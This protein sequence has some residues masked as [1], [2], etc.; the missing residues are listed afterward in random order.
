M[1]RFTLGI[2]GRE[3]NP[4]AECFVDFA[5]ALRDA[6]R[7]L[8][9]EV[10]PETNPGRY[11]MFGANNLVDSENK[12]PRD[13]IIYNAEQ[14]AAISD[15]RFFLQNWV[16]YRQMIVWDYSRANVEVL[17]RLG[18]ERAVHCPVGYIS[19]M[20][21]IQSLPEEEQDIDVLFYGSVAG[22]RR[23][24]LDALDAT[25]LRVERLFGVYGA[26]RDKFIARAKVVLN[27]RFYPRGIFEIFRV[28]HL[29]ANKKCVLTEAGG[30]DTELEALADRTCA[31]V[32]RANIVEMCKKLVAA[33]NARQEI[34]ETG[35]AEFKKL[36][37]IETVRQALEESAP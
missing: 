17:R 34:A 36:N 1:S 25:G 8:G 5:K 24:I 4:H 14:L 3:R 9:H 13:S 18:I 11:I 27:L 30:C 2:V 6:L 16:Q 33:P 21:C 26:E 32:E 35:Y 12:I 31:Y 28:S 19:S 10:V 22:P 20:E 37:F 7:A 15:P 29:L 23:E